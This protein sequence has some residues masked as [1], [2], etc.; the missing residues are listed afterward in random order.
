MQ[1]FYEGEVENVTR[2]KKY[3][4]N[5]KLTKSTDYRSSPVKY[6]AREFF[7][8]RLKCIDAHALLL[9]T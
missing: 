6:T 4:S 3:T 2:Q 9:V 5:A 1:I 7:I 8:R